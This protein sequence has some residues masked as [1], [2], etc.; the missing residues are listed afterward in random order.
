MAYDLLATA[1]LSETDRA[2]LREHLEWFETHLPIPARFNRTS[3]KG[4]HRRN[5][6]SIAWF[7]D[8]ATECLTRMH[9]LKG[10]LE[11]YGHPV[12]L[13]CEERVGYIVHEDEFQVIAE[14]FSDTKTTGT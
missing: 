4:Y 11:V 3:S 8:T 6:R 14:P 2:V 1:D 10:V 13:V 12:S 9:A 7:R 5:T